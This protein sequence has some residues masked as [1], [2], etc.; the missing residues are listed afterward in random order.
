M[1]KKVMNKKAYTDHI[2]CKCRK[3]YTYC[4]RKQESF[5][6]NKFL[7]RCDRFKPIVTKEVKKSFIEQIKQFFKKRK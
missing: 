6:T 2:C 3:K 7:L 4:E 5:R 1:N